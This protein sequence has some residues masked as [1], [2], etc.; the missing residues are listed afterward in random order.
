MVSIQIQQ[1]QG[2]SQAI[3]ATLSN[4]G[5][6]TSKMDGSVWNQILTE[7]AS[8]ND[9]NKKTSK[10]ALYSGGSDI[11]GSYKQNFVVNPN[12]T[13]TI[14]DTSWNKIVAFTTGKASDVKTTQIAD[15]PTI[16]AAKTACAE[17]LATFKSSGVN[18]SDW[19]NNTCT[20]TYKG[21]TATISIDA[22][23]KTS[24]G[25]DIDFMMN[26]LQTSSPQE[27]KSVENQNKFLEHMKQKGYQDNGSSQLATIKVNGKDTSVVKYTFAKEGKNY[28]AYLDGNGN[29]VKA[30][31]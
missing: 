23:G 11:K 17:D 12:Q 20:L 8:N 15:T 19:N 13:V 16:K 18:V 10:Q 2:I 28:V 3:K 27:Q 31:K 22:N 29:Q 25:G 7:V 14:D 26:H 21:K 30:D 1:G 6:D 4:N 9:N 24:F 5:I